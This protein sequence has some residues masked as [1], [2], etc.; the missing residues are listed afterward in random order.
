MAQEIINRGTTAGDGTGEILFDA[1]GKVNGNFTEIYSAIKSG[2]FVLVDSIDD[3]PTPSAGA[4]TLVDKTTYL[5]NTELDLI[6][7]RIVS[8]DAVVNI[9]GWS[10][11]TNSITSTGL[12]VGVPLL[13]SNTTVKLG[14]ITIK[15]IDTGISLTKNTV[16]ALDWDAVNFENVPNVGTINGVSNF[17]FTK[18]AL[19]NSNGLI[20]DGTIDTIGFDNC[21]FTG[22]GSASSIVSVAPTATIN[23]RFRITYSAVVAFS[24]TVGIDFDV[25]ATIPNEAYILDTVNFSGGGTYLQGV[26]VTDNKTSFSNCVGINNSAEISQYYMNGNATQTIINTIGTPVKVDGATSSSLLTQKFTNTNNRATYNG[27]RT[28]IFKVTATLSLESGNN[29]QVG[30]YLAKNGLVSDESEVYG[31]TSGSG[32]AENIVVQ[33]L[34]ELS[35]GDFIEVFAENSTG[36]TD[37][38]VTDLNTIIQ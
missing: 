14:N 37:I 17:I 24:S 32:R 31:T 36:T 9:F 2:S 1:F 33:T 19:L 25:S 7:N 4:I 3:L 21:L 20:F 12:G 15:N 11:E 13:T 29:N 10:S 35:T 30:V 8:N 38:T 26:Q 28:R 22:N 34:F 6:G 5:I 16:M 18:S 23:R 27:S